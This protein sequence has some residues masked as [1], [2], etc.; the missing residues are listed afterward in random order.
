MI[1]EIKKG[2]KMKQD[3][4]KNIERLIENIKVDYAKWMTSPDMVD[5]FNEGVKVSFGRKYTKVMNGSSVW[6]F[7][8]NGDGVLKGI[9]YKK[10][11]V[12]KAASWRG[13]AKHQRGSIFDSGTNWFAWTGPRY[14]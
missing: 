4:G 13:P 3:F 14:L 8:A 6:G 12:F 2:N 9:P 7:I 5:R 1:K 10:G 11:D